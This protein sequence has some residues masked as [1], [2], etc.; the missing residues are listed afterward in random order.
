MLRD[1]ITIDEDACDG[2]GLCASGCPEGALQMVEGKA[3]LVGEILCDGLGAC[4]SVCPR[5]AISVEK[6]EAEAYD[7]ALTM[8]GIIKQGP[9]TIEAHIRHLE[10]HGQYEY[11]GIARKVLEERGIAYPAAPAAVPEAA[12]PSPRAHAHAGSAHGHHGSCPGSAIRSFGT[13]VA[14]KNSL[15]PQPSA[16]AHWPVQLALANPSAPHYAGSNLL[17]AADCAAFSM[18]DFH[19]RWLKG[20]TLA[21][22][23]PKLDDRRESYIEKIVAFID[24]ALIDTLS[25]LVMEVPCCRGLL[26]MAEEARARAS[27]KLPLKLVVASVDGS[28]KEERWL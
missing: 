2:C 10:A 16:L 4:V 22:A 5:G 19:P 6:R 1:I 3:R 17:L 14:E 20:K 13:R 8:E 7:E 12:S 26:A 15:G 24:E 11:L 18:G 9:A 27:R 23:C 25:V 21:I 28:L